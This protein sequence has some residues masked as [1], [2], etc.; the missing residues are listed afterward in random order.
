MQALLVVFVAMAIQWRVAINK[1]DDVKV[2]EKTNPANHIQ[3][4]R[5]ICLFSQSHYLFFFSTLTP[6]SSLL[7]SPLTL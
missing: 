7:T 5:A 6:F 1:D 2:D 3:S 4:Q